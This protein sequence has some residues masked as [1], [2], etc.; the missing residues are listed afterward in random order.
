[1]NPLPPPSH[2]SLRSDRPRL[3]RVLRGLASEHMKGELLEPHFSDITLH[4]SQMTIIVK[5]YYV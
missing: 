3:V 1:M 5:K 2:P 4:A